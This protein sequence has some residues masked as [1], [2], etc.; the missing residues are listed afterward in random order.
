MTTTTTTMTATTAT[1]MT[2]MNTTTTSIGLLTTATTTTTTT[3]A[4]ASSLLTTTTVASSL[5]LSG[6]GNQTDVSVT[7][8]IVTAALC[9][10][11]N[12]SNSSINITGL[13]YA[14][15]LI[16]RQESPHRRLATDLTVSFE[17]IIETVANASDDNATNTTASATALLHMDSLT[18]LSQDPSLLYETMMTHIDSYNVTVPSSFALSVA[19]PSLAMITAKYAYG[20]WSS[21]ASDD[22]L[23]PGCADST[24]TGAQS[25]RV[26]C[27]DHDTNEEL[28]ASACDSLPSV[29]SWQACVIELECADSSGSSSSIIEISVLSVVSLVLVTFILVVVRQL[30]LRSRRRARVIAEQSQGGFLNESEVDVLDGNPVNA[31][32]VGVLGN[33]QEV[34]VLG[35]NPVNA[36]EV[37]GLGDHQEVNVLGDNPEH[38]LEV[39]VLGHNQE[40]N[41]LGD[42]QEVNILC[43]NLPRQRIQSVDREPLDANQVELT[44]AFSLDGEE[45]IPL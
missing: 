11:L 25:R 36:L 32:E 18:T 39:G 3:T 21:C 20:P 14:R 8:S 28:A 19:E 37:G 31:L 35:N 43:D 10:H 40:V 22:G 15:R 16:S 42:N 41:V 26:L 38:A 2:T 27:L 4:V 30:R 23:V 17:I 24:V 13:S 1:T 45:L 34:N 44:A 6:Y 29:A 12:I 33:N 9:Q 5:T 7:T